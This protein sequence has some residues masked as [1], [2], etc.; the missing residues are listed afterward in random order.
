MF[1]LSK[2]SSSKFNAEKKI[3][4]NKNSDQ[5]PSSWETEIALRL[6]REELANKNVS[7][8]SIKLF[9]NMVIHDLRNPTT[10][11]SVAIQFALEYF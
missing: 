11:I 3:D 6:C 8:N 7:L 4:S 1:I 2:G 5:F 10:Q 9:L